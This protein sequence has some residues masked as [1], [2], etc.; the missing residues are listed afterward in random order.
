MSKF[1][2]ERLGGRSCFELPVMYSRKG[3]ANCYIAEIFDCSEDGLCFLSDYPYLPGT[4]INVKTRK[5]YD[6][7]SVEVRWSKKEPVDET[8]APCFKVGTKFIEPL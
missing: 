4:R 5:E 7:M 3:E 1:I 8:G 2:N 6:A